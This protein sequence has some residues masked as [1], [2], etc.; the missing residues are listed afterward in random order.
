MIELDSNPNYKVILEFIPAIVVS[1]IS[2]IVELLLDLQMFNSWCEEGCWGTSTG[3]I[4]KIRV[5]N[6]M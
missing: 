5:Y 6:E 4:I 2:F 3:D 1:T